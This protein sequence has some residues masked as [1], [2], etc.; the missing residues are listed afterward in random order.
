VSRALR[1]LATQTF[2]NGVVRLCYARPDASAEAVDR[3]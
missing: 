2:G 3:L 1:L